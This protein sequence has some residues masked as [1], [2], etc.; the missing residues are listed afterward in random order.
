MVDGSGVPV[1]LLHGFTL[2][3]R[4]WVDQV[5]ALRDIAKA[6]RYDA[7]GFGKSGTPTSGIS[8]SNSLDLRRIMDHLDIDK[9]VLVGFSMGGRTVLQTALIAPD[10]VRSA[11]LLAP[12]LDGIPWDEDSRRA[13]DRVEREAVRVSIT[14]AKETWLSHPFFGPAHRNKMVASRL[15]A[16]VGAYSRFHWVANDPRELFPL[17]PEILENVSVSTTVIVGEL[18]IPCFRAMADTLASHIPRAKKVV[19]LGAGHLASMEAPAVV[20]RV[21]RKIILAEGSAIDRSR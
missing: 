21:L 6:V 16:M 19:V 2:D 3:M 5:L 10:R 12:Q 15:A 14:A 11:V 9:A 18:E 7:R 1:V 20:N 17:K 8:Y 13:M 4:M